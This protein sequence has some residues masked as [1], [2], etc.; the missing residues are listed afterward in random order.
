MVHRIPKTR[1]QEHEVPQQPAEQAKKP[2]PIEPLPLHS[3]TPKKPRIL[4]YRGD[5]VLSDEKFWRT[6]ILN[7]RDSSFL[8][9]GGHAKYFSPLWTHDERAISFFIKEL[10]REVARAGIGDC[11][12][13]PEAIKTMMN[14]FSKMHVFPD[15]HT[16]GYAGGMLP[17]TYPPA[18]RGLPWLISEPVDWQSNPEKVDL[19][20]RLALSVSGIPEPDRRYTILGRKTRGVG[21]KSPVSKPFIETAPEVARKNKKTLWDFTRD[22]QSTIITGADMRRYKYLFKDIGLWLWGVG[23]FDHMEQNHSIAKELQDQTKKKVW[24]VGAYNGEELAG[25]IL[26]L[27]QLH[28]IKRKIDFVGTDVFQPNSDRIM[29]PLI[30]DVDKNIGR[31]AFNQWFEVAGPWSCTP[32]KRL[33][34]ELRLK[35]G[36][37]T[38]ICEQG[39]DVIILNGVLQAIP[40]Q[41]RRRVLDNVFVALK[42]GGVVYSDNSSY[43]RMESREAVAETIEG[44]VDGRRDLKFESRDGDKQTYIIRKVNAP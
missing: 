3:C 26:C 35:Q 33:L 8:I 43:A 28:G 7:Y 37:V 5:N 17:D 34:D 42:P 30:E 18:I 19:A 22:L 31:E 40:K 27:R 41:K 2:F 23:W 36:D 13:T 10:R 29:L 4:T 20:L 25:L 15:L 1:S 9:Y 11:I 44:Y 6:Q 14:H 16:K 24:Y 12:V 21:G 38:Q 39:C 32:K